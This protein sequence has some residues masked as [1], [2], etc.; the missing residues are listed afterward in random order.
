MPSLE[1]IHSA[2]IYERVLYK[3]GHLHMH[4]IIQQWVSVPFISIFHLHNMHQSSIYSASRLRAPLAL[5]SPINMQ[6]RPSS[7]SS[8]S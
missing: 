4:F 6:E 8:Y 7:S 5:L 2:T 3:E 1:G